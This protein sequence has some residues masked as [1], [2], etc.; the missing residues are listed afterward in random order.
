MKKNTASLLIICLCYCLFAELPIGST[1]SVFLT[2]S[3]VIAD[4]ISS[5]QSV[6]A[7]DS[8]SSS[9][10]NLTDSNSTLDSL[11]TG[12]SQDTLSQNVEVVTDSLIKDGIA[13]VIEGI[14]ID[15]E[16]GNIPTG[17]VTVLVDSEKITIDS[18]GEFSIPV[19]KKP[20][21]HISVI[22]TNYK[23]AEKVITFIDGKNNYFLA[24]Q[25]ARKAESTDTVNQQKSDT[26][27]VPWTLT[28][29][30]I[31]SRF[32][33]VIE[34]DSTVLL[35]DG[36]TVT[37]TKKVNFVVTT[38]ISGKHTFYL[39]IPGYHP[40]TFPITLTEEDKQLFITIPTTIKGESI[41]RREITVSAKRL[42]VHRSAE[43]SK[44]NI[45]RKELQKTT[46]TLNDPLR[47][48]QTLP[49]VS[50]ESDASA[51]LIIRGG[52]VNEARA[53]LDGVTLL[54]PYHFGGA[55]SMFNQ[56]AMDHLTLYKTGFPAELHNA[57]SAILEVSSRIPSDE[58]GVF[59]LDINPH[60]YS[61]YIGI[62]LFKGKAGLSFSSQGSFQEQVLQLIL[63]TGKAFGNKNM[64]EASKLINLP[65]YKDFS[66][67]FSLTPSPRLK[68]FVNEIHCSDKVKFFQGDSVVD[69][70]F[71]YYKYDTFGNRILDTM[72]TV[73]QSYYSSMDFDF[74]NGYVDPLP[75]RS[76]EG[77][78]DVGKPR[79]EIDTLLDYH[80]RYNILYGNVNY[81][82]SDKSMF[83]STFAWQKRWW[84][85]N[86]P[87]VESVFDTAV[88]DMNIDQYNVN[89]GWTYSGLEKHIFKT[90]IQ[91]DYTKAAYN[92]FMVRFLHHL[93]T[94][95]ST[96]FSDFWGPV[97]GDTAL[98]VNAQSESF[99]S[100]MMSRILVAYSGK[101]NFLNAAFYASDA[102]DISN[103]LHLDL[104][105]R[106][107]YSQADRAK[108]FSPRLTVKYNVSEKNE[109]LG[110]I[111]LY[112]QN[113]YDI[114]AIALS[115]D[116]KPE[117]VWHATIGAE[118]KI[119]PWMTQKIDLYGKYYYD[120]TSEVID[121]VSM[122][123]QEEILEYILKNPYHYNVP[124]TTSE[125]SMQELMV[126]AMYDLNRYRTRYTNDGKGTAF[127]VEYMLRFDPADFWF[128]WISLTFGKS[129]R[130][131]HEN[132]KKHSFPLDRPLLVSVNNYYRL[133]RKYEICLKY[134]YMSGTPYTSFEQNQFFTRIG[135]F[136]DRRYA[137]YHR[138]DIRF[139]KGFSVRNAKGNFY[140]EI[141][142]AMNAPNL[143]GR[144][145]KT[146]KF[147][148]IHSNMPVTMLYI[149][150]E[151]SY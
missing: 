114:A 82:L 117:K 138:L 90:G 49:G 62:P 43:I 50:S 15:E 84:D 68:I 69:V 130:Q 16:T 106:I 38:N 100:T 95:G 132:W 65:D 41:T 134:R 70:T 144:D 1:A 115:D 18:L 79:Y 3:S 22:S 56:Q 103:K 143:F 20:Y 101:R 96:N 42:P 60:Q 118:T 73:E 129:T 131:R 127:G 110:S 94:E 136:N 59:E 145:S 67:G 123:T 34:S 85:L 19:Q 37:V 66:A 17:L 88:Y 111:G 126:R 86:F 63:K 150:T 4:S 87:T 44:M 75:G 97:N 7:T 45:S 14:I 9:A 61:T 107:E 142:N 81:I 151:I 28:G 5:I 31:D 108:L 98:V 92:V 58:K 29:T 78:P 137:A 74:N 33:L 77:F 105:A 146:K 11:T 30:I 39:T 102:W 91:L 32:D 80:S 125:S 53:F 21:Y 36:D 120:L 119:L 23:M 24:M 76:Y 13:V 99:F 124:D 109:V 8:I 2:D 104:G 141:W 122:P 147:V 52:D 140:T 113:N 12:R 40:V 72:V 112:T 25:L 135:S 26:S 51:R 54:Q 89:A 47:V 57:Q 133:P 93:I 128:G 139:S 64:E 27:A 46:A 6:I 149:G 83:Y 121:N 148:T 48:L 10:V 116:L 55:R 71:K 35:F